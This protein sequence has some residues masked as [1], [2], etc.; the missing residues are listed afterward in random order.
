MARFNVERQRM[1]KPDIGTIRFF[2]GPLR[3]G[4]LTKVTF[5]PEG[6]TAS[7]EVPPCAQ[8]AILTAPST[9]A[10]LRLIATHRR[11]QHTCDL[12]SGP[13]IQSA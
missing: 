6:S 10:A 5:T 11:I 3:G 4:R 8:E 7:Y 9:L 1:T 12:T 2:S 13:T